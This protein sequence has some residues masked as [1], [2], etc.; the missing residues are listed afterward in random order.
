[1]TK[2]VPR[3]IAGEVAGEAHTYL[4]GGF[5]FLE[6]PGLLLKDVCPVPGEMGFR[7]AEDAAVEVV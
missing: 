1:M 2:Q 4:K 3:E 7:W 6:N 5:S